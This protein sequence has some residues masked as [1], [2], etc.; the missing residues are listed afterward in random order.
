MKNISSLFGS[1]IG[2]MIITAV[3][4]TY[5]QQPTATPKEVKIQG[6]TFETASVPGSPKQWTKVVT[7][8]QTSPPWA[9]GIAFS[10]AVLIGSGDQL[11]VLP[12]MVRYA[13]VKGGVN[14]AVMYISPNTT[15]RF[16]LP[17]A[18]HIRAYY[19]DELAD[20]FVL[21]PQGKV[22]AAWETQ[23]NKYPGLLLTVINTPWV[24]NDYSLSPDI[25]A[26]QQQ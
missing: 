21:K 5:A 1:L 6:V 8:F 9:D 20:D 10:Y 16:G 7:H 14:R 11:R 2:C 26:G 23:F 12:G 3:S 4:P 25:F 17:V 24:T 22:S 15:E 18:V 13:N 19:K